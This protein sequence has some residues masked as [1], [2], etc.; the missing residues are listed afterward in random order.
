MALVINKWHKLFHEL[1]NYSISANSLL[2]LSPIT[3]MVRR[4]KPTVYFQALSSQGRIELA[5]FSAF[6]FPQ[7]QLVLR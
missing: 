7:V 1:T 4:R 2:T 3:Q 5:P 6:F